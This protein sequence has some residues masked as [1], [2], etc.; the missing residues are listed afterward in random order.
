MVPVSYTHLHARHLGADILAVHDLIVAA[1]RLLHGDLGLFKVGGSVRAV[2]GVE[3]VSYTHLDV[4]KR[5]DI[6]RV[7]E[8]PHNDKG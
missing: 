7:A 8:Q 3:P 2:D 4:Y 6:D 1:L 5:Q